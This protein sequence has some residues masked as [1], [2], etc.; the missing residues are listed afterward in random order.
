MTTTIP[1]LYEAL[2]AEGGIRGAVD[3]FYDRVVADPMLAD[4]F[5]GVDMKTL[6]RHQT[7]MLITATGGPTRYSGRDMA[8]AHLGLH[9]TG[10]AFDRVVGHLGAT[11]QA[12]GADDETIGAV[13]GALAPLR[14]S[15]VTA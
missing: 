9:I 4:Y 3:D 13:V 12:G 5:T 7:D 2:G 1:S 8:A 14:S 6:R 11:L 15:I 10:G